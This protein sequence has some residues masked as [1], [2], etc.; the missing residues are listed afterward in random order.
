M[1][2]KQKMIY[3]VIKELSKTKP[4][5]Q[6]DVADKLGVSREYIRQEVNALVEKGYIEKKYIKEEKVVCRKKIIKPLVLIIKK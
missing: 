4:P 1:S 2:P 3:E 5:R 6:T